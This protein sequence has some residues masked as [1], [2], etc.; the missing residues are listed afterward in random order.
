M[1]GARIADSLTE[2]NNI[3][4]G[5]FTQGLT[6]WAT[7]DRPAIPAGFTIEIGGSVYQFAAEEEIDL[8]ALSGAQRLYVVITVDSADAVSAEFSATPPTSFNTAI[9]GWYT[10]AD[11]Y[12]PY[13]IY[14]D[15]ATAYTKYKYDFLEGN[16]YSQRQGRLLVN[17][18]KKSSPLFSDIY[19]ALAPF[20]PNVGDILA[21]NGYMYEV[22]GQTIQYILH[23]VSRESTTSIRTHFTYVED[24]VGTS[25][26]GWGENVISSSGAIAFNRIDINW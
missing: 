21:I 12:L 6:N 13:A 26:A 19:D 18:L 3:K 15:G 23:Y 5:F 20:I 9:N 11:R 2:Y 14:W 17:Q 8:G 4:K 16:I 10:G 1:A 22:S 25:S 24:G 7:T